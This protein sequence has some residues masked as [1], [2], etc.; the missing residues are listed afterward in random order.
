MSLTEPLQADQDR[1]MAGVKKGQGLTL[2][3]QTQ[4]STGALVMCLESLWKCV[5]FNCSDFNLFFCLLLRTPN[6]PPL[7]ILAFSVLSIHLHHSP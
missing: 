1:A 7:A 5:L 3:R 4:M 2:S 6:P